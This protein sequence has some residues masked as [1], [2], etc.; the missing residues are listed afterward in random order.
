MCV[1]GAHPCACCAAQSGGRNTGRCAAEGPKK[2][3]HETKN[4]NR[5]SFTKVANFVTDKFQVIQD[6]NLNHLLRSLHL[7]CLLLGHNSRHDNPALQRD[8]GHS[9]AWTQ[10]E[11]VLRREHRKWEIIGQLL[12]FQWPAHLLSTARSAHRADFITMPESLLTAAMPLSALATA[13]ALYMSATS[14]G[15]T[16]V[17]VWE[18]AS[19]F[20]FLW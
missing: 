15:P 4:K 3:S 11:D 1:G 20:Y 19:A 14:S 2:K 5:T 13:A 17:N 12:W 9:D 16:A 7:E 10:L 8:P 18:W 6:L